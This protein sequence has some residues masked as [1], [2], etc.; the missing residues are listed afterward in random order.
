MAGSQR[1]K[2]EVGGARGSRASI[3]LSL[4]GACCLSVIRKRCLVCA[5]SLPLVSCADVTT[6]LAGSSFA[7]RCTAVLYCGLAIVSML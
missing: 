5:L 6:F 3:R 2:I 1:V 4:A 7:I